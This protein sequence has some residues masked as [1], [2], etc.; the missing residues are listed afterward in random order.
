[1]YGFPSNISCNKACDICEIKR[2]AIKLFPFGYVNNFDKNRYLEQLSK[3][4]VCFDLFILN[5]LTYMNLISIFSV[6]V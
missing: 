1:M 2:M 6:F 4:A 3:S 5:S